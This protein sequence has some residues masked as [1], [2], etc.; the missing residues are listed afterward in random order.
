M[1]VEEIERLLA[2]FYEGNTTESQEEALRD[3]FR[4][5][6]VPEHL[7]KDKE[8]FLSLYQAA[9]RD[10]EVPAGLGDKL[11]LLIDEKAEEEQR[12]FRPNNAKRNWR[13]IGGIAAT[14]LL[15]I[16]IGYGVDR[17]GNDVCPPTPQDTFSD[18]EEAYRV[19]QA[20]LLE[21]STNLNQGIA[22]IKETQVDMKKSE[23]GSKKRNTK[24]NGYETQQN[25][26][27]RCVAAATPALP[28]AE[29]HIQYL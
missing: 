8:I 10:V 22:Q 17:L 6:E 13:W 1:K 9:D 5:T 3:Y 11:S 2:E 12:F 25:F 7:L 15:L 4:T 20:T 23:S 27:G 16:G 29:K 24:I 18:P 26:I 21:V 19:L 28:G 14:V